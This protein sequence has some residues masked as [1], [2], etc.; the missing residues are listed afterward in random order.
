MHKAIWGTK[1]VKEGQGKQEVVPISDL[2]GS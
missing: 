1:P 2:T